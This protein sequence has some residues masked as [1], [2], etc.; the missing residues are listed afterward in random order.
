MTYKMLAALAVIGLAACQSVAPP[1]SSLSYSEKVK[2]LRVLQDRCYKQGV[3]AGTEEEKTCIK[4]EV[5]AE[6]FRRGQQHQV[7]QDFSSNVGNAMMIAGTS[8]PSPPPI[9]YQPRPQV[10][11]MPPQPTVQSSVNGWMNATKRY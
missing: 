9:V 3:K 2:L 1:I 6:N 7:A 5:D 4:A 10:I 11:Y 8:Q